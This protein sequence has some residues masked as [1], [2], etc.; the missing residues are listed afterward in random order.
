M[1]KTQKDKIRDE[2]L[3]ELLK[4][5]KNPEDLLGKNG[6]FAELK[7]RLLERAMEAEIEDHLGYPKNGRSPESSSNS[8]NGHSSKKV[9]SS[10]DK[11]D[12]QIPRDRDGTYEPQIIPKHQRRFDG[13]D[14]KILAM[15]ARG[16]SVR[17]IQAT[18]LEIYNVEVSEGII[19]GVTDKVY[20]D[21]VSWQNRPLDP[22]YPLIF[23]DCIVVK[24]REDVKVS[25]RSVYLALAINMEG[26]KEL[27]G[28]WI[29]PTE[30]ARFWLGVM[31]ELKN[32]GVKDLFI[33]SV[34]GLKGFPEAIETVFPGV[35]V[36][37][38]IVHMVRNSIK[39]VNWKD[40]K[41][42]C[43]DLKE[44]YTAPT[45][46]AALQKLE[47]FDQKWNGKYPTIAKK[48][49]NNWDRIIPFFEYPEDIRKVMYT[50]NAIESV[51]RSIRKVIK[52]KGSFPND[53]A[54][55]KMLYLALNNAS[56]K[57]TMPIKNWKA[58]LNHFAIRFEGRFPE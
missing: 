8:R 51:N 58:A 31:T 43:K 53:K 27:L 6:I 55:V 35:E 30:G 24:S 33:A 45:E 39:Y 20:E 38:C 34:D 2:L 28:M 56:K 40:R 19:T 4:D 16:M 1:A 32:R 36:Q 13:F 25:N 17:D 11:I 21:V 52:A 42:V 54:I 47:E 44:V 14:D 48:W 23:F 10:T 15:Y 46:S 37:L 5:Y 7:K 57:W 49:R 3:D 41:E 9:I 26:K 29:A 50:T 12:I 18:L 22:I